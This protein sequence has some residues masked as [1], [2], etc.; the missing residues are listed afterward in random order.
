MSYTLWWDSNYQPHGSKSTSKLTLS[1]ARTKSHSVCWDSNLSPYGSES[2]AVKATHRLGQESNDIVTNTLKSKYKKSPLTTLHAILRQPRSVYPP[3]TVC[4]SVY[5]YSVF[6]KQSM[7]QC[8]VPPWI[9]RQNPVIVLWEFLLI[10]LLVHWSVGHQGQKSANSKIQ[11]HVDFI[12]A[13]FKI[14]Y[15]TIMWK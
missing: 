4:V 2:A 10:A 13:S 15:R 14:K 3:S 6:Y 12:V 1:Q 9:D 7:Q 5:P 11:S 8:F